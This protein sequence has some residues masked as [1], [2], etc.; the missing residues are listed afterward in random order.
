[1]IAALALLLITQDSAFKNQNLLKSVVGYPTGKNGYEEYLAAGDYASTP[2]FTIGLKSTLDNGAGKPLWLTSRKAFT[3]QFSQIQSL[4]SEGN[5][6]PVFDPRTSSTFETLYP[7]YFHLKSVS[8]YVPLAAISQFSEGHNIEAAKTLLDGLVFADKLAGT[9]SVL[10]Y[11]V[12]NACRVNPLAGFSMNLERIPLQSWKPVIAVC[13]KKLASST[14]LDTIE[15]DVNH[16]DAELTTG[17]RD[18]KVLY[19]MFIDAQNK[20][21]I[22]SQVDKLTAAG[23][24]Q[25]AEHCHAA[26]ARFLQ[27]C[28]A[29]AKAPEGTWYANLGAMSTMQAQDSDPLARALLTASQPVYSQVFLVELKVRAQTRL[30]RLHGLIQTYRMTRGKLPDTLDDLENKEACWD[31]LLSAPYSYIRKNEDY[32][33]FTGGVPGLGRIDLVIYRKPQPGVTGDDPVNP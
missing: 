18:P 5:A 19:G 20:D 15:A 13:D 25:V 22:K 7:E 6:K 2:A 32:E 10:A 16:L 17:L 24:D 23:R 29:L 31:P 8:K 14:F 28:K 1:M 3:A 11:L 9:G 21:E 33:L 26:L 30:L 27:Q 4:L 12:G